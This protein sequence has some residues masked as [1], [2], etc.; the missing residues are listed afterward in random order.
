MDGGFI[1]SDA[2]GPRGE[3][4]ST[5]AFLGKFIAPPYPQNFFDGTIDEVRISNSPRSADW[6]ATEYASENA[7]SSFYALGTSL[8]VGSCLSNAEEAAY[9]ALMASLARNQNTAWLGDCHDQ[10]RAYRGLCNA[11]IL[12]DTLAQEYWR[13]ALGCGGVPSMI[14]TLLSLDPTTL[15]LTNDI[16]LT[17]TCNN[18]DVR[19]SQETWDYYLYTIDYALA[20]PGCEYDTI[21][22]LYSVVIGM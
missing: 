1:T 6:I 20:Y 16:A 12:S 2:L 5:D 10:L 22:A 14:T 9:D 21:M 3:T 19:L 4:A 18:T 15:P 11:I 13:Y 17:G 8:S 7:P